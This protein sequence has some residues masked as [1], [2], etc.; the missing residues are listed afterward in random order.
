MGNLFCVV[1]LPRHIGIYHEQRLRAKK[2]ARALSPRQQ[3]LHVFSA[4]AVAQLGRFM[5]VKAKV[6][7]SFCILTCG[8][9]PHFGPPLAAQ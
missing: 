8:I 3:L 1:G 2:R 6:A 7:V 4:F 9:G 5:S